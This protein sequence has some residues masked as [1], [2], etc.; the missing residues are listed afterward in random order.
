MKEITD[1]L[2]YKYP[3]KVDLYLP[4]FKYELDLNMN[5]VLKGMGIK[6]AFTG[7]ADFSDI[8][9]NKELR[10]IKCNP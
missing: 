9:G 8:N 3:K 5:E 4:K 10:N 7:K 6:V 1:A 2:R